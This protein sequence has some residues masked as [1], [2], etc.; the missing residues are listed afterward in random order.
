VTPQPAV[1]SLAQ[2]GAV[3]SVALPRQRIA[4]FRLSTS[5][6]LSYQVQFRGRSAHVNQYTRA[7]RTGDVFGLP[8]R[9][10]MSLASLRWPLGVL[11][12]VMFERYLPGYWWGRVNARR[13]E[14]RNSALWGRGGKG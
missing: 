7:V 14:T 8:S 3:A 5:P 12:G 4:G 1:H 13:H 9:I 6:D 11:I 2:L 10:V